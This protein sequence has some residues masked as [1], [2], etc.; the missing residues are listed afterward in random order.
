M[1]S[2]AQRKRK[3]A[4]RTAH[5]AQLRRQQQPTSGARVEMDVNGMRLIDKAGDTTFDILVLPA[6]PSRGRCPVCST[7]HKL[8]KAGALTKHYTTDRGSDVCPG[9][10]QRADDL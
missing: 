2:K 3:H 7:R 1:A 10:G 6:I 4:R 9:V 8:T 5:S